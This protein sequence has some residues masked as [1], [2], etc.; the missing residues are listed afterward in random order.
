LILSAI[1]ASV[2]IWVPLYTAGSIN[3]GYLIF[4]STLNDVKIWGYVFFNAVD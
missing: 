3:L 2:N 4:I 1:L